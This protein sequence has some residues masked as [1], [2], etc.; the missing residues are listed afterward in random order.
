VGAETT[1]TE[2]TETTC[3]DGKCYKV[4]Y[5]G[6]QFVQE[7]GTWIPIEEAASL[8]EAWIPVYIEIDPD[9]SIEL[10][11]YN[12]SYVD[13]RLNFTGDPLDYPDY[14]PTYKGPDEWKC[15]FKVSN[16]DN[17]SQF[18]FDYKYEMKDGE[19]VQNTYKFEY[20]GNP[21]GIP[22]KFGGNST[23]V[24]LQSP[25]SE[26]LEDV[27]GGNYTS[28]QGGATWVNLGNHRSDGDVEMG[29]FLKWNLSVIPSG[30]TITKSILYLFHK[31]DAINHDNEDYKVFA[32]ANQTWDEHLC[33]NTDDYPD[34]PDRDGTIIN[35]SNASIWGPEDG[36]YWIGFNITDWTKSEYD[37]S[38][39]NMSVYINRSA[40][41]GA[42][43]D[44][45][46]LH[47]KE[48]NTNTS[49]RPKLVIRYGYDIDYYNPVNSTIVEYDPNT[50]FTINITWNM[51]HGVESVD[52]V[53]IEGNWSGSAL[54]YTIDNATWPT[55]WN[56]T[57]TTVPAGT[58]YWRSWANSTGS[59]ENKTNKIIFRVDQNT[60]NVCHTNTTIHGNSWIDANNDTFDD[61]QITLNAYLGYSG[62]G[63]LLYW[64]DGH[65]Q[66]VPV[67]R[68]LPAGL[69]T[70]QANVTGNTNFTDNTTGISRT[71]TIESLSSGGG[72]GPGGGPGGIGWV[73]PAG[74]CEDYYTAIPK[75][76]YS[77]YGVP[78]EK[79]KTNFTL[80]IFNKNTSQIFNVNLEFDDGIMHCNF[81]SDEIRLTGTYG[82]WADLT[83]ILL[84]VTSGNVL[85]A[86]FYPLGI[87]GAF[88]PFVA[89]FLMLLFIIG[90]TW[91]WVSNE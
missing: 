27:H 79:I 88:L 1:Y 11:D 64:L 67:T 73:I 78:N 70:I 8:K 34:C 59:Y 90:M 37:G 2:T 62:S 57:T 53:W 68:T 9:F 28:D 23:T 54:N 66:S 63:T 6:I 29:T 49:R 4:L 13:I 81:I 50:P 86:M 71:L 74:A 43:G 33:Q 44:F 19:I 52:T 82:F 85:G 89:W 91:W 47:S 35:Q 3:N 83:A 20:K 84:M 21:L 46:Q 69:H 25:G 77:A 22:F 31:S 60:S 40:G 75:T 10:F 14:C 7:N 48:Y 32:V 72:G 18:K 41:F 76:S 38:K 26:N 61:V 56:F 5:S 39:A 87:F 36:D 24:V 30:E 16:K 58:W 65:S 15:Q 45:C 12:F 42:V 17:E 80:E 51:S 55:V